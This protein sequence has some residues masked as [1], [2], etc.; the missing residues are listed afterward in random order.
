MSEPKENPGDAPSNVQPLESAPPSQGGGE[1]DSGNDSIFPRPQMEVVTANEK[2][3]SIK[4]PRSG[5][6]EG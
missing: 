3:P 4:A 5:S 6:E 1:G 2:P